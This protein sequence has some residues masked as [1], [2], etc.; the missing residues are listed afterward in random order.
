MLLR[1]AESFLNL[2]DTKYIIHIGRSGKLIKIQ[3]TFDKEDAHHLMGLHYLSDRYDPRNRAKIFKDILHSPEY[4]K[5][6]SSSVHWT[7]YLENRVIC[8]SFLSEIIENNRTVIRYNPKRHHF[9]SKISAE[10][11]LS[12]KNDYLQT[13]EL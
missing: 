11:L 3:L 1:C 7:P 4:L 8:T 10:Y 9:H 2:I 12:C 13:Q 5:K 6:L